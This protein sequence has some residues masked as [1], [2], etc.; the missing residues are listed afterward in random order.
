MTITFTAGALGGDGTRRAAFIG[1]LI[2]PGA[3]LMA[4]SL[5][6][7]TA[8]LPLTQG[9]PAD[10]P[11]D[12]DTAIASGVAAAQAGA[13]LRQ[14]RLAADAC[15]GMPPLLFVSGGDWPR[16][17]TELRAALMCV[18]PGRTDPPR[19]LDGPVLDGLASLADQ[20]PFPAAKRGTR[21]GTR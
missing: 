12:T 13:L 6:R 1:G 8:E 7:G 19:W 3:A 10:F 4:R 11:T 21:P 20:T 14:W 2:L 15:P 17:Q 18:A 9:E 16:V 5:A